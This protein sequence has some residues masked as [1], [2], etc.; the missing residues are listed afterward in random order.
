M[1]PDEDDRSSVT[2]TFTPIGVT[3]AEISVTG[4]IDTKT[5]RITPYLISHQTHTSV[6]FVDKNNFVEK[7]ILDDNVVRYYKLICD[8]DDDDDDD[9]DSQNDSHMSYLTFLRNKH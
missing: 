4:Q 3:V 1:C 7:G 2:Q 5:R 6:A 9:D 8:D